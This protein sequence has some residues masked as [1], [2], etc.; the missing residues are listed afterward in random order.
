MKKIFLFLSLLWIGY[1]SFAQQGDKLDTLISA[2]AK[3]HKFN[4][5]AL[6]AKNGVILLNKGYGYRNAENKVVN[7][8]QTIF[9]LGSIT[10]QFTSAVILKLQEEKKLSVSDKLSKY[11]PGYPKGDS[12]TIEHLLTHTSGIYNYTNDANFM[13]NEVTKP[14]SREKIMALFK[15][16]PL[17]FSPGTSWNY[18]NSGYSLLG[19]IIEAVTGKPYYQAVRKYI[20][21]PLHMTHSGFDFTH[22]KKKEKATGYFSLEGKNPAIAPIVDSSVSFSAGAIYSTVGDLFLWHKA[23]QKNTVLSKAQQEK[24]YTPVKNKYGYGWGI[25]SIE[26]K[27]NVSHGGG[28]HGFITEISRVPE[29]DVCVILLSNASDPLG[30]ITKSI[31]A[32]LY[33]REYVL[34]KERIVMK[35]PEEKLKQYEGE[36]ELNKDLHVIINLKDGELVATPTGQRAEVLYAEKEDFLFVQSQDIQLEFTR[37]EKKEVDGFILH[38]G[39]QKIPCKKIK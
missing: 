18:S 2:Y 35:L 33:G 20:F 26:G 22:L 6:V 25:D 7:N 12:I 14:A 29:D 19:Y 27:R 28:I 30:D 15:D 24:A 16:K 10:K 21:T 32:I 34:P 31:I 38:Q 17:D 4:G 23:L 1:F 3:L 11:F 37:N 39:G 5:S 13:S 9:Q 36:Y 8:E